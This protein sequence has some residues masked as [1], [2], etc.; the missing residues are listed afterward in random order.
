MAFLKIENVSVSGIAACVPPKMVENI[1]SDLIEDKEELQRYID[2]T[3][4]QRRYI[5]EDGIC[6]SDLCLCAAEKL[7]AELGWSKEEIECLIMVTQTPLADRKS[8]V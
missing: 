7:I 6:S 5:A 2:T 4:V 1:D 8:V 3:G